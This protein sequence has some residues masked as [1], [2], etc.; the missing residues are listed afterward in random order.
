MYAIFTSSRT[1]LHESQAF[2]TSATIFGL[3]SRHSQ[4]WRDIL[5]CLRRIINFP[6]YLRVNPPLAF[7]VIWHFRGASQANITTT[8][9][10]FGRLRFFVHS[11]DT[12]KTG[13][14]HKFQDK[15]SSHMNS[16]T[17]LTGESKSTSL[18][19]NLLR[20]AWNDSWSSRQYACTIVF[21]QN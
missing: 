14:I 1:S 6:F 19:H 9:Q 21:V 5:S 10:V 8:Y 15:E 13:I 7:N 11:I 4:V 3:S 17:P 20:S 2:L 18:Q 12:R 16:L